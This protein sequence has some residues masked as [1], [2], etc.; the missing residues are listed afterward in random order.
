MSFIGN[1]G[2]QFV[3]ILVGHSTRTKDEY[4]TLLPTFTFMSVPECKQGVNRRKV[5]M[6]KKGE[7]LIS[8]LF[9]FQGGKYGGYACQA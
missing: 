7:I 8:L 3:D 6:F 2:S 5:L 1:E 4:F 9:H